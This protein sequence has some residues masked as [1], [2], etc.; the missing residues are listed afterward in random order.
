MVKP[1]FLSLHCNPGESDCQ[2]VATVTHY[3]AHV[4]YAACIAVRHTDASASVPTRTVT[5]ILYLNPG[6]DPATNGGQLCIYHLAD[7]WRPG[8]K[9]D[10]ESSPGYAA[11][12]PA[13]VVAPIGNRLVIF[14]SNIP[15]EVLPT[16]TPRYTLSSY[17]F[18]SWCPDRLHNFHIASGFMSCCRFALTAWFSKAPSSAAR[19]AIPEGLPDS[20][21]SRCRI[22]VSIASFR[23]PETRWTVHDLL[24]KASHPARLRIGIVWQIDA[25]ADAE[26]LRFPSSINQDQV[27]LRSFPSHGPL[28][29]HR[30][31]YIEAFHIWGSLRSKGSACACR[32]GRLSYRPKKPLAPARHAG[33]RRSCGQGRITACRSTPTCASCRA[34]MSTWSTGWQIV[35]STHSLERQSCPPTLL[36]MRCAES[37]L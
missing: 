15:H 30:Q 2:D 16:N 17:P 14:E 19:L 24:T 5:A 33:C 29:L 32:S 27:I 3:V 25:S 28:H 1:C 21:E 11:G 31:Y 20:E 37:F 4:G 10:R 6:W 34:G 12:E 7:R 23:D 35:S 13:M 18:L 9:L 22:F 26:I 8:L 36:A